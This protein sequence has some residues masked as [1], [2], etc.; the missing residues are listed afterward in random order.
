MA[1]S[2]P[3]ATTQYYGLL[4]STSLPSARAVAPKVFGLIRPAS[5]IDI[6]CGG[7]HWLAAFREC[8]VAKVHGVDGTYVDASQLAIPRECFTPHDLS[9]PFATTATYDLAMSLEVGE[10]L[11]ASAAD[12]LIALLT[13]LAPAVFFSAAIP[14]QGGTDHINE[15]WPEYW[16]ERFAA[17]GFA[18]F[19]CLRDAFWGHPDIA[20]W[21]AQN[22]LLFVRKEAIGRY[23]GLP[24]PVANIQFPALARVHHRMWL[25]RANPEAI[26]LRGIVQVGP[27]LLARRL[28][29]LFKRGQG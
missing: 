17:R 10:H 16:A 21:Y 28:S 2:T 24:E 6:G 7:G 25:D 15:Q 19:D 11:P 20:P 22:M 3:Y 26:G 9:Q 14:F 27:K 18:T 4:S 29:R 1:E 8:G 12:G 13:A 23:P 5:V